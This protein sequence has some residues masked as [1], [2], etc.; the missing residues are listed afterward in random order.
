MKV[1]RD[2]TPR[3]SVT[4]YSRVPGVTLLRGSY[5]RTSFTSE[6]GLLFLGGFM[7]SSGL[8]ACVQLMRVIR[9]I[10]G[11]KPSTCMAA[12]TICHRNRLRSS[13]TEFAHRCLRAVKLYGG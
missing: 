3:V 2:R 7:A 13:P 4:R 9:A 10:V 1:I 11:P 8:P 5:E 12:T 6:E